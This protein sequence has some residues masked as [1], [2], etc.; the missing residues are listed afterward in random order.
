VGTNKT[1]FFV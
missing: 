1:K